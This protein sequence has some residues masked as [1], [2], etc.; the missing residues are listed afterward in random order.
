ML[1]RRSPFRW[2]HFYYN[3][4]RLLNKLSDKLKS[5]ALAPTE[6]P[7]IPA[8]PQQDAPGSI[9]FGAVLCDGSKQAAGQL[10][11]RGCRS[12]SGMKWQATGLLRE[13]TR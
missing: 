3:M 6:P 13:G 7:A 10:D 1:E 9:A 11:T 12:R 2:S 8:R 4:S 5:T